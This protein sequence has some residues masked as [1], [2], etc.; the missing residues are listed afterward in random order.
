MVGQGGK[1]SLAEI[2]NCMMPCMQRSVG[3]W[4]WGVWTELDG[5]LPLVLVSFPPTKLSRMRR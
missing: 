1:S 5:W 2:S 3:P 4:A